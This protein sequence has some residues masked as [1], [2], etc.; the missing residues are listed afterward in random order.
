[1]ASGAVS[2]FLAEVSAVAQAITTE[3]V[4][5]D[6]RSNEEM[7]LKA[8]MGMDKGQDQVSGTA[9]RISSWEM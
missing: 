3:I 6:P 5:V 7:G 9:P 8:S 4:E 1:M 2:R